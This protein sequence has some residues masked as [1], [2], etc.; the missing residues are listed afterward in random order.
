[1]RNFYNY[2]KYFKWHISMNQEEK[3]EGNRVS[4]K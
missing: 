3:V 1:M 4:K 2:R